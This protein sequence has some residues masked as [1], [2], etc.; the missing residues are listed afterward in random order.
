MRYVSGKDLIIKLITDVGSMGQLQDAGVRG[1][2]G[3]NPVR[4]LRFNMAIRPAGRRASSTDSETL[5]FVRK[6]AGKWQK[7]DGPVATYLDERDSSATW[8]RWSRCR[9]CPGT[10]SR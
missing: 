10:A 9:T 6:F 8:S 2:V 7:V 4:R 1:R 3:E 5:H